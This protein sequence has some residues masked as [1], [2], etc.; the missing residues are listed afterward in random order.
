MSLHCPLSEH[1]EF[2]CTHLHTSAVN[3]SFQYSST[4]TFA[5]CC[6]GVCALLCS[7][8]HITFTKCLQKT[9]SYPYHIPHI[10]VTYTLHSSTYVHKFCPGNYI[11][12]CDIITMYG[13]VNYVYL[14]FLFY[15]YTS[16][17]FI[18]L[19]TL[20]M[21]NI[22]HHAVVHQQIMVA[23]RETMCNS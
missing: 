15:N 20:C 2:T 13:S 9:L 4:W 16:I 17:L 19:Y 3:C 21:T 7:Y 10:C 11:A 8:L 5:N 6:M 14:T 18:P 23:D 12:Y 1:G 22:S